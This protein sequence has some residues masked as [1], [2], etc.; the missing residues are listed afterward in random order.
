MSQRFSMA[1][2]ALVVASS[3]L[4]A[5]APSVRAATLCKVDTTA[6]WYVKQRAWFDDTKHTWSNDTLRAALLRAASIPDGTAGQALQYGFVI[7]NEFRLD[8]SAMV[9]GLKTLATTR[10]STWPTRSVVGGAGVRAVWIVAQRDT[11][12]ARGALKRMM[13]AGPEESNAADVAILDDRM[14]LLSGRKQLYG[15]HFRM[16]NGKA[17]VLPTEDLAHI[18]MRREAAGLP[19]Y[20][21]SACLAANRR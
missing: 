13:E 10:G 15:S 11:G 2:C 19:P 7:S 17:V 18:D 4:S 14:R 3:T 5:Q 21:V 16:E 6:E 9:A 20:A 8:D 12:L 1:L